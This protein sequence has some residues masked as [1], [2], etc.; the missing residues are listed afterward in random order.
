MIEKAFNRRWA[1]GEGLPIEWIPGA[2]H[3]SNT[4]RPD[5]INELIVNFMDGIH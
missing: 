4:D 1:E 2:G 5:I 3:N